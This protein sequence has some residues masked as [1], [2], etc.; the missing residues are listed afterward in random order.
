MKK[1]IVLLLTVLLVSTL[2]V[3]AIAEPVTLTLS[4]QMADSHSLNT[5]ALDFAQAVNEASNGEIIIDVF[6]SATLGTETENLQALTNG[7]L[8]IAIIAVEFYANYVDEAGIL[9]LPFLYDSYD[10]AYAKIEGEGGQKIKDLVL[11]KTNVR[12]LGYYIQGF[13][14]IF[15]ASKPVNTVEDLAGLIIRIPDSSTYRT[16]F[17]QLGAS[18][19]ATAWGEVYT[20]L[21]TGVVAAMENTPETFMAASLQ[22]VCDYVNV[23]NHILGPTT[24]SMSEAVYE[25]LTEE[26][27]QILND[28]AVAASENYLNVVKNGSE[29]NFNKL[30]EAGLT[31]VDT[32]V[33]TM[34]A[35]IDYDA[36]ACTQSEEGQAIIAIMSE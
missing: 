18:P 9:C 17:T 25:K 35:V 26:Q 16:T 14:E 20:A 4:H 2:S 12:I 33:A 32:D 19:T 3:A 5:L 22:E 23:T 34:R 1:L 10:D 7:T 13:R 11:E 6:P 29:A 21:D 31:V 28:C 24:F 27:Q 36:F 15:T 8:D 30:T